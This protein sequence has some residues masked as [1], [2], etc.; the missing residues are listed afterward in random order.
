MAQLVSNVRIFPGKPGGNLLA[1][2]KV[3]LYEVFEVSFRVMNGSKGKFIGWPGRLADKEDK[4][5][6]KPWYPDF[7]VANDDLQN[8]ITTA[9]MSEYESQAGNSKSISKKPVA[10]AQ[11]NDGVP[12]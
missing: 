10:K 8:E 7:K 1:F 12:F 4:D 2:G 9:L 3:T 6:K 5:G 11:A